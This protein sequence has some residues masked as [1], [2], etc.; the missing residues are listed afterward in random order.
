MNSTVV[1]IFDGNCDDLLDAIQRMETEM[2]PHPDR[3]TP[4]VLPHL[5]VGGRI[6]YQ[7]ICEALGLS[8]WDADRLRLELLAIRDK[9]LHEP[10][11]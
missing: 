6:N 3:D 5:P 1:V 2:N 10:K 4:D 8:E 9:I 7:R 11:P